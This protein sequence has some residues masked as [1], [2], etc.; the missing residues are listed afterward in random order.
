MPRPDALKYS[1]PILFSKNTITEDPML[2][3]HALSV[4][5]DNNQP[6][7]S[8]L[9]QLNA[10]MQH[11]TYDRLSQIGLTTLVMTGTD[12]VL[13]DPGNS[14]LI[15]ERVRGATLL[16]FPETGHVFFTE[17]PDRVNRALIEFLR[18]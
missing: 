11:D 13:V 12:D 1:I 17:R 18:A 15:A 3:E 4:M 6:K 9:L 7:S 16:E 14:R 5:A 2:V 8:Y 10:V